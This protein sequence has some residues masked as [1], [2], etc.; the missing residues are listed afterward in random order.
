MQLQKHLL[1]AVFLVGSPLFWQARPFR[2]TVH[3]VGAVSQLIP[4]Y[5][6]I[7]LQKQVLS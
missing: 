5:P 3:A 2:P 6:P 7:Q 4:E 1:S